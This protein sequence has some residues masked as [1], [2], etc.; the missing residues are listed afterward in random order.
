MTGLCSF[1]RETARVVEGAPCMY[2]L[3]VAKGKVSALPPQEAPREGG[4][5]APSLTVKPAR[6]G[7]GPA[8]QL[9][10]Q[11]ASAVKGG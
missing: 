5:R 8:T 11:V 4:P 10:T 3:S 6:G 9:G 2:S 1:S 7:P